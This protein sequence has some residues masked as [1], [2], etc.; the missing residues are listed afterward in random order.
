MTTGLLVGADV[1]GTSTRVAVAD[2]SG[3][4]LAVAHEAAGNPNAVGLATSAARIR[5]AMER[6]L[7]QALPVSGAE[8]V[9]GRYPPV[10]AVVLGMAGY[11]TAQAAGDAFRTDCRPDGVTATPRLVSDLGVAYASATSVPHGYVVIAGTGT[12]AAEI[13]RGEIVSR[14]GAWGWLLGDEGGGFWLGREAVRQA[15]AE[16]ERG[17]PLGALSRRVLQALSET[18]TVTETRGEGGSGMPAPGSAGAGSAVDGSAATPLQVLLRLPYLRDPVRLADL[19]PLVT[20]L[21]DTDPAAAAI[22]ARAAEQLSRLLLDLT[23]MPGRPVVTA[24]SVLQADG[25]IRTAF[26][27]QVQ[28]ATGSP[29]LGATSGLVGALW[30]AAAQA[31]P[32][33]ETPDPAIHLRLQQTVGAAT[34]GSPD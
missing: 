23:P 6:A 19:A 4:V 10:A 17:G 18:L 22:T 24:G 7:R 27:Q 21:V 14:R 26:T 2:R 33:A 30:L 29:V 1:G 15:L 16:A 11:G 13:D 12:G 31:G 32:D 3:T 20:E 8:P 28:Q 34:T 9:D 5:T 25:P